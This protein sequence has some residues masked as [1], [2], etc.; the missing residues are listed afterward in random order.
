MD[1]PHEPPHEID[2]T[3]SNSPSASSRR[4]R[5]TISPP[6]VFA[7]PQQPNA[8]RS[9]GSSSSGTKRNVRSQMIAVPRHGCGNNTTTNAGTVG[10]A[11][12]MF[13][14]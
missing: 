6:V 11:L 10:Q 5:A 7:I 12:R 13:A 2:R 3:S 14:A 8:D 1:P 4:G 9:S